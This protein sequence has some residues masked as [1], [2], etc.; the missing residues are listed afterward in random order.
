MN[1]TGIIDRT[2]NDTAQTP[3]AIK[4]SGISKSFANGNQTIEVLKNVNLTVPPQALVGLIGTSGSGK[5]T[6]LNI[7]SGIVKPDRG[8]VCICGA[9]S[10]E[11]NDWCAISYMFQD[12][13]LLPWRTAIRNVE[14]ALEAG[15]LPKG[16]RARRSRETLRLVQLEGFEEAF[17]YQLSGGMRSR[18]A[19]A[20]SLVTDPRILLM[21]E[22]FSRLDAQT[23]TL[24]HDELLRIHQLKRMTVVFVTHDVAEAV[25]L[26]DEVAVMSP[27]P[28]T[29]REVVD[30]PLGRPG[31]I[32]QPEV[33]SYIQRLR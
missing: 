32:T 30:I 6:L 4:L 10:E 28:G 1:Q 19:L 17:P 24:M 29:I 21:D 14:L 23:R 3:P 16:E 31:D 20:R 8:Q 2:G 5:S 9:A 13:R 27:R 33:T 12:D 26:A 11:F 18:V 15:S 7:I 25:M 22:P